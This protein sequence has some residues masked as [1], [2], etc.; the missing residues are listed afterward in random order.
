M[1]E[2]LIDAIPTPSPETGDRLV[3]LTL[4]FAAGFILAMLA[5]GA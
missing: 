5:F 4:A 3:N 1:L 2:R